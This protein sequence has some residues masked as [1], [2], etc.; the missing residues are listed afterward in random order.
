MTPSRYVQRSQVEANCWAFDVARPMI[1]FTETCNMCTS[2]VASKQNL[3]PTVD[4]RDVYQVRQQSSRMLV[5]R[6]GT[7]PDISWRILKPSQTLCE[8][9]DKATGSQIRDNSYS[10]NLLRRPAHIATNCMS[11]SEPQDEHTFLVTLV[12]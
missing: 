9:A 3:S 12:G 11:S 6:F 2:T 8:T 10:G 4:V 7:W 1:S 5:R